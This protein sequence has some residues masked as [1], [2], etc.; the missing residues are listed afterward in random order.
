VAWLDQPPE[1]GEHHALVAEHVT[2]AM[3]QADEPAS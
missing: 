2:W 1:L 3:A